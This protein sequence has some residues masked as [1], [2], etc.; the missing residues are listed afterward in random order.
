MGQL[1]SSSSSRQHGSLPSDTITNPKEQCKATSTRSGLQLQDA[2]VKLSVEKKQL[3]DEEDA[4]RKVGEEIEKQELS[5]VKHEHRIPF[6]Q[7]LQRKK[8]DKQFAKFL[9]VFKKLHIN[10]PFVE[11][12]AQM[13]TYTKFMK[14]ILS[15]KRK[16]EDFETVALTEE[17]SAIIQRKLPQ[18]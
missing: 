12:L 13:P 3:N 7:R 4:S 15:N 10:I 14:H 1:A 6:P 16:L 17:C 8:L 11:A 18:N 9:E 5:V 2:P